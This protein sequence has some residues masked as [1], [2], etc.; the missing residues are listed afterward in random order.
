MPMPVALPGRLTA[1]GLAVVVKR[2]CPTCVLIE[3]VLAQLA[4]SGK[5]LTVLTQDD[6]TFP[7]TV[8]GVVDD[9][10]LALSWQLDIETV[11]TLIRIEGGKEVARAFGWHRGEW[12]DVSR[13]AGLGQSLP[14]ERPGCGSMTVDPDIA[15]E[16]AI[17]FGGGQDVR[18]A[19]LRGSYY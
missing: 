9:T 19:G 16:L 17:R 4:G 11:P 1:D 5:R 8:R 18:L 2:D 15:D 14:A 3:P 6:P 12:E 10:D 13:V 7:S